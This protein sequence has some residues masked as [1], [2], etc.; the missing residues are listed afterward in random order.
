MVDPVIIS[1][2]YF[3]GNVEFVKNF[4]PNSMELFSSIMALS[5]ERIST[6]ITGWIF[7]INSTNAMKWLMDI[8]HIVHQK[9]DSIG[10]SNLFRCIGGVLFHLV[11]SDG[12][13]RKSVFIVTFLV[14][15]VGDAGNGFG[16]V[17]GVSFEII[18]INILIVVQI[19][20]INK[21]PAGLP[22]STMIFDVVSKGNTFGECM[23]VFPNWE[24]IV[25]KH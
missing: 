2:W 3:F 16:N 20:L 10:K 24:T 22:A 7:V 23:L 15:P 18:V 21:M 12:L 17:V 5:W 1:D 9:S 14:E 8:A 11:S 6:F 25:L 4:I 13:N 19:R